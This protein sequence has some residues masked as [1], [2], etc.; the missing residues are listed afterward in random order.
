MV[1]Y[2]IVGGTAVN[3]HGFHRLSINLPKDILYDFDI[4]YNPTIDNFY[5]LTSALGNIQPESRKE[6]KAIIFDPKRAFL[7]I[8]KK[9]FKLE[10][11]PEI[12]GFD[13]RNYKEVKSRSIKFVINKS[14]ATII[15]FDDLI[16]VKKS[17]NREIDKRDV[18][19]LKKVKK[20]N[21]K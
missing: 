1:D 21:I 5:R 9:P 16:Y 10:L 20:K 11:L 14:E 7:R 17:T 18:E 4:W 19:E 3:I 12:A 15:G 13:K 2:M 8:T 6:L